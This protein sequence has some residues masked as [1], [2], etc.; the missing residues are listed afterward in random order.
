MMIYLFIIVCTI[1]FLSLFQVIYEG[2]QYIEDRKWGYYVDYC[3]EW[4]TMTY[5]PEPN[6]T[7]I[8]WFKSCNF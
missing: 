5:Q 4:H 1:I 6:V 7:I 3:E 2:T 8:K